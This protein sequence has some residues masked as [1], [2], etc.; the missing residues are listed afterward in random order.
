MNEVDNSVDRHHAPEGRKNSATQLILI[1]GLTAALCFIAYLLLF[2][3][4]N[5]EANTS[6]AELKKPTSQLH[7]SNSIFEMPVFK[8]PVLPEPVKVVPVEPK[9]E[10][11]FDPLP[12]PEPIPMSEVLAA[13]V[14]L[15]TSSNS[16][17]NQPAQDKPMSDE[18]RRLG[19]GVSGSKGAATIAVNTHRD[20]PRSG[21]R[22]FDVSNHS[23]AYQVDP[24]DAF[25]PSVYEFKESQ[26]NT[27]KRPE[28][29]EI[30][31][32]DID[33][34]DRLATLYGV[35]DRLSRGDSKR[36]TSSRSASDY[37]YESTSQT[38]ASRTKE[39]EPTS[40]SRNQRFEPINQAEN[41]RSSNRSSGIDLTSTQVVG[42]QAKR[43]NLDYL[44]KRGT[45]ISCVLKT[46][47]VSDQAGFISCSVTEN[48]YS[49]N[50]EHLL[51]PRGSDVLG[52]YKPKS[53]STGK[54]R[55]HAV[56]DALTTPDGLRV[57]LGSP[58]TGALGASGIGGQI[59]NHYGQKVG[60][61]ILLSLF[62][63]AIDYRTLNFS[64]ES[65]EYQR[66]GTDAADDVLSDQIQQ[67]EE[68]RPTL[69][70]HQGSTIG[71]MIARD[72]SFENV[73]ARSR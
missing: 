57:N 32:S 45:Y 11:K 3:K 27:T 17:P 63:T 65:G 68:I 67:Y 10:V 13:P 21:N 58:S 56:W 42:T 64:G 37:G 48:I 33:R 12:V 1:T 54:V 41:Q 39:S 31:S 59:N 9:L 16:M 4:K 53:L 69:T 44:L 30:T 14:P 6:V 52:E 62:R 46:R 26:A 28:S 20:S 70:K 50:G 51:I 2:N 60:I 8:A 36:V 25:L 34:L 5:S 19:G 35:S 15:S 18:E 71:I 49:A 29:S 22:P 43:I 72:V 66:T 61:P 40:N 23:K 73:L 47:I 24:N 55:L 38:N 7:T